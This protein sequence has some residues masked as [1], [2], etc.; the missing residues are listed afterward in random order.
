FASFSAQA[1]SNAALTR[2]SLIK[3]AT[4]TGSNTFTDFVTAPVTG[5]SIAQTNTAATMTASTGTEVASFLI[6]SDG[7]VNMPILANNLQVVLLPGETLTMAGSVSTGTVT[8]N[9]SLT[10]QEP[11]A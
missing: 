8:M 9:T 10:W 11:V 6:N 3:N 1:S 7:Y 2:F 5:D 4:L